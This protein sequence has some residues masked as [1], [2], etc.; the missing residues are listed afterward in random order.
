M[1]YK[2]ELIKSQEGYAVGCLELPG[3]WSQGDSEDEALENIKD[4][5]A[6]YISVA[7]ELNIKKEVRYVEVSDLDVR[8]SSL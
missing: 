4:A 7:E 6:N 1:R 2:I 5:I 8:V 3:C